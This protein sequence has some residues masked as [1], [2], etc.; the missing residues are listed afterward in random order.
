MQFPILLVTAALSLR[1]AVSR[2]S[3]LKKFGQMLIV[4]TALLM[5]T[6][7]HL[8]A[9]AKPAEAPLTFGSLP[10]V[11]LSLPVIRQDAKGY[12]QAPKEPAY[13]NERLRAYQGMLRARGIIDSEQLRLF[14]AQLLQENGALSENVDGDHGCSIGI[15]QRNV[16]LIRDSLTKKRFTAA[17]FRIRY[18]AWKD[19]RT[20]M[21]WMADRT[22][23]VYHQKNGDARLT[24]INHNSPAAARRG[25]DTHAGYYR[26]IVARS[27][28]LSLL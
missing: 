9:Q 23:N 15:P 10:A 25:T 12:W 28:T 19:W 26:K 7:I 11:S 21:A 6:T 3:V 1:C 14:T 13:K 8:Y 27:A 24:I 16:C 22:A 17:T 5:T 20:Q 2:L 18:P 4:T